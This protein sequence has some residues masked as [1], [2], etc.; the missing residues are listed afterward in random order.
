MQHVIKTISNIILFCMLMLVLR[1]GFGQT[2]DPA[3]Y[4]ELTF[5]KTST[6][7][8]P[9]AI[10]SVDRGS[11]DVLAQKAKGVTNILQVKAA[12][13][14]FKETNLTVIT[15]DG[16]I[17]H[18]LVRYAE[19]P[20]TYTFESKY[21][22]AGTLNTTAILQSDVSDVMLKQHAD[23]ILASPL[24]SKVKSISGNKMKMTLQG[25]Y[26]RENVMFYHIRLSNASNIS[27]HADMLRFFI[28]DKQR[29]K[30]TAYQEVGEK[31][32]YVAGNNDV[33]PANTT[34]DMVYALPKFTIP[35]VKV[36]IVE[37]IEKKGGRHLQL[38]IK[39]KHIMKALP[40]P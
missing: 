23:Y 3:Q 39:N 8:F 15:A 29:T 25:I 30:R 28:K 26:I 7:V 19:H 18:F 1:T 35:D 24:Y 11:R 10:T 37:L 13:V 5:Y 36:L 16:M 22:I 14:N 9:A 17:H 4:I 33:I 27:F 34:I 6:I 2:G 31:P 38:H 32:L 12:R 40:I 20:V 21:P